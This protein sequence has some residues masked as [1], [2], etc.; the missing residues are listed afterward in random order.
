MGFSKRGIEV[1]LPKTGNHAQLFAASGMSSSAT[2]DQVT[3]YISKMMVQFLIEYE[4]NNDI[5]VPEFSW[6]K[7]R[8]SYNNHADEVFGNPTDINTAIFTEDSD[9]FFDWCD[10]NDDQEVSLWESASC[11]SKSAFWGPK[12]ESVASWTDMF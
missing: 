3:S 12:G 11:G 7:I 4:D 8:A 9:A 2:K 5:N 10:T 6:P 1:S